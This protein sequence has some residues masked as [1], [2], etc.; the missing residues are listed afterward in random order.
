[1]KFQ[2]LSFQ[3]SPEDRKATLETVQSIFNTGMRIS[4]PDITVMIP[5]FGL[6]HATPD[7]TLYEVNAMVFG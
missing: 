5:G 1:M 6:V 3:T 4:T 7:V 2:R